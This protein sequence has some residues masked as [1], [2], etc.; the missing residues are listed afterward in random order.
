MRGET[1]IYIHWK[2]SGRIEHFSNLGKLFS[3][4]RNGELCVSRGTLDRKDLYEGYENEVIHLIKS[5]VK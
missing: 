5:S 3:Y 1:V 4:Y 2:L